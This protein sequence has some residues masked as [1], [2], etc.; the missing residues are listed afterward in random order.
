ML[1]DIIN[2]LKTI[3]KYSEIR[4]QHSSAVIYKNKI[5]SIG[6][7]HFVNN[8]SPR[9]TI[10]AEVDALFK[11]KKIKNY[12]KNVELI[13]IRTNKTSKLINSKPCSNCMDNIK[14]LNIKK[15]YFSNEFGAID[16]IKI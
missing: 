10:H 11:Y 12:Y 5:L 7:N 14:K 16:Y 15:I 1:D 8:I 13:V 3:S 6:I 4:N 2:K 9:S